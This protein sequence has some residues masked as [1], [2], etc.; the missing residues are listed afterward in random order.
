MCRAPFVITPS[1]PQP[2]PAI[3]QS[4][5]IHPSELLDNHFPNHPTTTR[6][7]RHNHPTSAILRIDNVELHGLGSSI[8]CFGRRVTS[9]TTRDRKEIA[10]LLAMVP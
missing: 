7:P 8:N 4:Q 5:F 2:Y 6:Q 3:F 1:V 10:K 9:Y